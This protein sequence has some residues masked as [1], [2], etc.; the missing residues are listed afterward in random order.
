MTRAPVPLVIRRTYLGTSE[1]TLR[2]Q[3]RA[4]EIVL[5]S[6]GDTARPG[7]PQPP[8]IGAGG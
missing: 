8:A 6:N 3:V 1:Q 2:H 4:L 7:V 5:R